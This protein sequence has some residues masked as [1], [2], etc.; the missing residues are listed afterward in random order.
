MAKGPLISW[1]KQE[2]HGPKLQQ[3]RRFSKAWK[4]ARRGYA[5]HGTNYE[6]SFT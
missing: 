6:D 2:K 4:E 5:S 3:R 1:L